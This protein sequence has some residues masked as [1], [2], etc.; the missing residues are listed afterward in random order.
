MSILLEAWRQLQET[1]DVNTVYQCR[2]HIETLM[3][4]VLA[5]QFK[6]KQIKT[7]SGTRG[8]YGI[9]FGDDY[10]EKTGNPYHFGRSDTY[11]CAVILN[12][13]F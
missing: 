1:Q 8:D 9:Y 11:K 13:R 10:D 12:K 3:N 7:A 6:R 5:T 2:T 4:I